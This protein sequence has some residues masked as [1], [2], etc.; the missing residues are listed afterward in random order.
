[1]RWRVGL[2]LVALVGGL[3]IAIGPAFE[4]RI[5]AA[6]MAQETGVGAAVALGAAVLLLL[7]LRRPASR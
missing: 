6:E 3:W 4:G 7:D 2:A 5:S 1:M